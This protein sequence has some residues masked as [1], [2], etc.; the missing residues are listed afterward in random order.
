MGYHRVSPYRRSKSKD[1]STVFFFS[2]WQV[3]NTRVN[4]RACA[5]IQYG[6]LLLIES[7]ELTSC[8]D[9]SGKIA[10]TKREATQ[11]KMKYEMPV[12][13]YCFRERK[14]KPCWSMND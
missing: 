1:Y 14:K 10:Q 9:P 13:L 5:M 2:P 11:E 4:A 6:E 12:G 7:S 3:L 8:L